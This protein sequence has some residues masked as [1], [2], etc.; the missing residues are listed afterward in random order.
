MVMRAAVF[1]TPCSLSKLLDTSCSK[2]LQYSK[3]DV[4]SEFTPS[5]S[6][7]VASLDR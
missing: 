6:D 4:T 3:R 5:S 1:W 2:V 7:S